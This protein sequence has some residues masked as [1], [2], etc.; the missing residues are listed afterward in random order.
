M[1]MHQYRWLKFMATLAWKH[2]S[3][4]LFKLLEHRKAQYTTA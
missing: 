1:S 3:K 4:K 2:A